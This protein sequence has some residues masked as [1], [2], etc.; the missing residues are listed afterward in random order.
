MA[1]V[2]ALYIITPAGLLIHH[3]QFN[4][5]HTTNTA[6]E[7]III[8]ATFHAI[9]A[10]VYSYK[11]VTANTLHLDPISLHIETDCAQIIC[12]QTHLGFKFVV[13]AD[14]G[15][16]RKHLTDLLERIYLFYCDYCLKNPFYQL[17]QP[18]HMD[19]CSKFY[20]HVDQLFVY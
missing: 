14:L 2:Y 19:N 6:N 20:E 16:T 3:R 12:Y 8:A 4:H 13:V 17:E 15:T 18:I 7:S 9:H 10:L 1:Y 11:P 5:R